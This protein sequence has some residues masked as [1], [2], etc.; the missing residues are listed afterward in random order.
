M[1]YI[2]GAIPLML[3]TLAVFSCGVYTFKPSAVGSVKSVGIPLFENETD[4]SGIR[5][6]LTDK[7]RQSFAR[8]NTLKVVPE[9]RSD[10]VI[11]GTV[12]SYKREAYTFTQSEEVSEYIVRIGIKAEFTER[13][14]GKVIWEE[15]EISNWGTYVSA[16]ENEEDGQDR[17]I[18]KIV[19][20]ILNKTV[21][22]W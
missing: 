20:D 14:S 9:S 5:E 11:R 3:L 16:G 19:E 6:K 1:K 12:V 21:K 7:L 17:A 13:K 22:G 2:S 10:S 8:D 4:E 18:D 15:A